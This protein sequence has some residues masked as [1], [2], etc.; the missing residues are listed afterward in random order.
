[1]EGLQD[2]IKK[3]HLELTVKVALLNALRALHSN[4]HMHAL[5]GKQVMVLDFFEEIVLLE[6][7][8]FAMGVDIP[9]A[10]ARLEEGILF[11]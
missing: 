9:D 4:N 10:L 5:C 7:A 1:M 8:L 2:Y 11:E 6:S 3:I